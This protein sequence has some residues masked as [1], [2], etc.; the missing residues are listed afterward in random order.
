MTTVRMA[1]ATTLVVFLALSAA[2]MAQESTEPAST[3]LKGLVTARSADTMTVQS[4][5]GTKHVVVL[6]DDTKVRMPKGLIGLRHKQVAWT[7]L[8][9]GL[10]VSIKGTPNARGQIVASQV[11]FNKESLEM[12]SRIQAGLAPTQQ[13]VEVNQQNIAEN[14]QG[15]ES[16][17]QQITKNEQETNDRFASLTDYDVKNE[18]R[19]YFKPGSSAIS[20][21][22][23]AALSQLASEALKMQGYLIEV[24]GFADSTG[25]ATMNQTLSKSRAEAVINHLLQSC[26]VPPRHL[27]APGAM[28]ISNPVASNESTEGRANNRRVEVKVM[29]NKAVASPTATNV[30]PGR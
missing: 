16:N 28:G 6:T 25:N 13:Q 2:T 29:V 18:F 30:P 1:I 4:S 21:K 8:M 12:A 22:D 17:K 14:R 23:K 27:L 24:K 5:D 9:P 10:A 7:A 19:V 3:Q 20:A 15:I 26:N 11:D